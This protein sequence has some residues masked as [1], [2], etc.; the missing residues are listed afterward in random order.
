[1]IYIL[2]GSVGINSLLYTIYTKRLTRHAHTH[3]SILLY[4]YLVFIQSTWTLCE[5][6]N[7]EWY[8][9]QPT[10]KYLTQMESNIVL[11]SAVLWNEM[12]AHAFSNDK[13]DI[14][15]IK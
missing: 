7:I 9:D 2:F 8:T 6:Q 1:M 5:R 4:I 3:N 15:D 10:E 11:A 13:D 12:V 14:V